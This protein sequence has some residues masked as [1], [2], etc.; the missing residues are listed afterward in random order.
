MGNTSLPKHSIPLLAPI[1]YGH[2]IVQNACILTF[3]VLEVFNKPN[4]VQN[5]NVS[6]KTQSNVLTGSSY[7]IKTE[8]T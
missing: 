3:R 6:S 7:S 2:L 8:V 1:V 5:F 4:T